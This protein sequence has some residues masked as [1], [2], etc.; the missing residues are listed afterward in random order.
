MK[1]SISLSNLSQIILWS[2]LPVLAIGNALLI[3]QNLNMRNQLRKLL[4]VI[5]EEGEVVPPFTATGL[6]GESIS[7]EYPG[8]APTR[9]FLFFSPDCSYCREQFPLWKQ[10]IKKADRNHFSIIGLVAESQNRESVGQY[11]RSIDCPELPVAFVSE[12][13][14]RSYKLSVTPTTLIVFDEGRVGPVWAGKWGT[15]E[16]EKATAFFGISFAAQ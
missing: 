1:L 3:V 2:L 15:E 6:N 12:Q 9:I 8:N 14:Q 4:P 7:M 10:L 11:L 5:L 13:T 16:L